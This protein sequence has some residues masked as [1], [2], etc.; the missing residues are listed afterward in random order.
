MIIPIVVHYFCHYV[1]SDSFVAPWTVAQQATLSLGFPKQEYLSGLPFSS[2]E[3]LL[4]GIKPVSP[5]LVGR[6]FTAEP[7]GK[8]NHTNIKVSNT[9]L[10]GDIFE[11]KIKPHN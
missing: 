10:Y 2:P 8:S 6:F 4:P 11:T 7:L 5:S 3:D 9:V 1:K